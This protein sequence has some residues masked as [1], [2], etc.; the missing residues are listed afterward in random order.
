MRKGRLVGLP[1]LLPFAIITKTL[2]V[3]KKMKFKACEVWENAAYYD[4]CEYFE[5]E[6]NAE[7]RF[8][9]A[10][11]FGF[12]VVPLLSVEVHTFDLG[13]GRQP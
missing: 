6:R 12:L 4:V 2:E 9:L 1:F 13:N 3:K 5:N 10:S 11:T 8:L 7:I